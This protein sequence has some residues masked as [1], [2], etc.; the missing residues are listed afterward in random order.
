MDAVGTRSS[1]A[2]SRR[3][4]AVT[5]SSTPRCGTCSARTAADSR[6]GRRSARG[7][8][9]RSRRHCRP[10]CGCAGWRS[11]GRRRHR[12]TRRP[13]SAPP[14]RWRCGGRGRAPGLGCPGRTA[15]ARGLRR[16]EAELARLR[17]AQ[18]ANAQRRAAKACRRP[19]SPATSACNASPSTPGCAHPQ[20]PR[21]PHRPRPRPDPGRVSAE[22]AEPTRPPN[23]PTAA[24]DTA[25]TADTATAR[26]RRPGR[27]A[28]SPTR[29]PA[30]LRF[31]PDTVRLQ[32]WPDH[33]GGWLAHAADAH[34]AAILI[35]HLTREDTLGGRSRGW[36]PLD[37]Q[38]HRITGIGPMPKTRPAAVAAIL[39][40]HEQRHTAATRQQRLD[41]AVRPSDR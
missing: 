35:G 29:G 22:P 24:A 4:S 34:G 27:A 30:L 20:P 36:Q 9:R 7:I 11:P 8:G 15:A 32:R 2:R 23:T 18:R 13:R 40:T 6:R 17:A 12:R 3:S 33:P 16:T 1:T 21:P 14:S 10:G 25:D 19:A 26:P 38:R 31:D 41:K 5:T 28:P 39:R 37:E